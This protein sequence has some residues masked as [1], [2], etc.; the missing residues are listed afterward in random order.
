MAITYAVMAGI[1]IA[2]TARLFSLQILQG[3]T[4]L[5]AAPEN[6]I[7][8]VRLPAARGVIYDRNGSLLVRNLPSYNVLVTPAYLPDSEAEIE[9]IYARLSELTGVPV[10]TSVT[11]PGARCRDERGIRQLV[12]ER[13]S[14]APYEAWPVACNVSE[15][16]AR[17]IGE[18]Q[19]D[20]QG[21]SI[22]AEPVRD[23]ATGAL[24]SAVLGYLGPIPEVAHG[25]LRGPGLRRRPGSRRLRGDRG[26][27]PDAPGRQQ[28]IQAGGGRRRRQSSA[29]GGRG[30]SAHAGL[31]P[32]P[33]D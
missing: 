22:E 27:L 12:E 32:A 9:T 14:I 5:E 19:V 33:D 10:V 15:T 17:I 6:R 26:R 2:F 29:R 30:H 23:Y 18:Q 31:Q 28:W 1:T 8:N 21:V 7:T 25:N 11:T 13:A 3:T 20:M 4:Y 16:V 24:T